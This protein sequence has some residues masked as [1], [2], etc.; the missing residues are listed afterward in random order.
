MSSKSRKTRESRGSQ[1]NRKAEWST[2]EIERLFKFAEEKK[3][4]RA[5][6][7]IQL[8]SELDRSVD[9]I[10]KKYSTESRKLK[11]TTTAAGGP[12]EGGNKRRPSEG[13]GGGGKKR[14]PPEGEGEEEEEEDLM[15]KHFKILKGIKNP[16]IQLKYWFNLQLSTMG[17][18][19]SLIIRFINQ[20]RTNYGGNDRESFLNFMELHL[21]NPFGTILFKDKIDSGDT[22]IQH[23]PCSPLC[24]MTDNKDIEYSELYMVYP[25]ILSLTTIYQLVNIDDNYV[26][27]L[28]F[29]IKRYVNHFKE[30]TLDWKGCHFYNRFSW[31]INNCLNDSNEALV[32]KLYDKIPSG[33]LDIMGSDFYD[34]QLTHQLLVTPAQSLAAW[35]TPS[36]TPK[37]MKPPPSAASLA[38]PTPDQF[39]L[40][41]RNQDLCPLGVSFE[42]S[43]PGLTP[44][45]PT[46]PIRSVLMQ[47]L[48]DSQ[49]NPACLEVFVNQY[50]IYIYESIDDAAFELFCTR[51]DEQQPNEDGGGDGGD[52]GEIKLLD[53]FRSFAR[54]EHTFQDHFNIRFLKQIIPGIT[55]Y[56]DHLDLVQPLLINYIRRHNPSPFHYI[57]ILYPQRDWTIPPN[58]PTIQCDDTHVVDPVAAV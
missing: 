13:G 55:F 38:Y 36:S 37:K 8:S 58:H 11:P 31:L 32:F 25:I 21:D 48:L 50:L 56:H 16:K 27:C 10:K 26:S 12:P 43:S 23:L 49:D 24:L 5:I 7:W 22:I 40:F 1:Y 39:D 2:V 33:S 28:E 47:A 46:D 15:Y 18:N 41:I 44:D 9:A 52:G 3:N 57:F 4:N 35:I 19:P 30:I 51:L 20:L 17:T 6:Q 54:D 53:Y 14:C 45:E 29:F 42:W 34:R